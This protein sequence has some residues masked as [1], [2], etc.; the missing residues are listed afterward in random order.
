MGNVKN[1]YA[2]LLQVAY[3]RCMLPNYNFKMYPPAMLMR[4]KTAFYKRLLLLLLQ[5][6][7]AY[8]G[9]QEIWLHM[10]QPAADNG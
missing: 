9:Y 7:G 4:V 10:R 8:V 3:V 1:V 2:T 6:L 5:S